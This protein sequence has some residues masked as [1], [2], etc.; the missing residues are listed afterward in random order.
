MYG[1]YNSAL[2][3]G[4]HRAFTKHEP[5]LKDVFEKRTGLN[6][7]EILQ[8][9]LSI[10]EIDDKITAPMFGWKD[11]NDYY[12]KAACYHRIPGIRVPSL[13]MNARDD[14]II[15]DK[16]IDYDIFKDNQYTVLGTTNHGGHLGY[17]ESIFTQE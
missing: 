13:F 8:K 16:A 2:G 6:M 4:V 9:E 14:P 3:S 10:L 5:I 1:I 12:T 7:R 11:R 17:H 15:G